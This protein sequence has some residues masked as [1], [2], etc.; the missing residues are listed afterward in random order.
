MTNI[1]YALSRLLTYLLRTISVLSYHIIL[2][3]AGSR[4]SELSHINSTELEGE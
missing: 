3:S 1:K 4:F 2:N